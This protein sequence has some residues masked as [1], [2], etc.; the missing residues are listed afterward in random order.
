M[1]IKSAF[2]FIRNAEKKIVILNNGFLFK[3]N[4]TYFCD[5]KLN[6]HNFSSPQC[7]MIL[8]KSLKMRI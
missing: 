8:Q 4:I 7:H 2:I 6:F 5:E 3:K 1:L